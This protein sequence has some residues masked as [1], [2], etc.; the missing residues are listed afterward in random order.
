[1]T[2]KPTSTIG[3]PALLVPA[4]LVALAGQAF[5]GHA[6]CI[7]ELPD[8]DDDRE[9]ASLRRRALYIWPGP[10]ADAA[11]DRA[12]TAGCSRIAILDVA[13]DLLSGERCEPGHLLHGAKRLAASRATAADLSIVQLPAAEPMALP[14]DVFGPLAQPLSACAHWAATSPDYVGALALP[15]LSGLTGG[16]LVA[17]ITAAHAEPVIV[18]AA[19][20]GAPGSNKTGA[21]RVF[22]PGL[23]A[24]EAEIGAEHERLMALWQANN[25]TK[26]K[27]QREK[28]PAREL[29]RL[30]DFTSEALAFAL[31]RNGRGL[32]GWVPEFSSLSP[33]LGLTGDQSGYSRT[34]SLR[35]ALLRACLD[36]GR[37]MYSRRSAGDE[38]LPIRNFA[39]P[40]ATT[41]QPDIFSELLR[42][43]LRDGLA[44]RFV[45]AMPLYDPAAERGAA[46]A[47]A[48]ADA[49]RR[50]AEGL[51]RIRKTARDLEQQGQVRIAF[52]PEA[53]AAWDVYA[54][55]LRLR[56]AGMNDLV[57][58]ARIKA[59]AIVARIAALGALI[60][61]AL[62][63]ADLQVTAAKFAQARA[64]MR[65]LLDHRAVAEACA[66]EPLDER[67]A[68]ALARAI[69]AR[70]AT[71]ISPTDVRRHWRVTN[72]RTEP[73]VR[74]ALIELQLAGWLR[75]T[76]P[77]SRNP[78]DPLPAQVEIDPTVLRDAR[79]LMRY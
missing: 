55:Q 69:V 44:D 67:R 71:L 53:A 19:A 72:L 35:A 28:Q 79:T 61:H 38:P 59:T 66:F 3:L 11:A 56:A 41:V 26:P 13:P 25:A 49:T 27:G 14:L 17:M 4:G 12:Q 62:A 58:G 29:I 68:R 6:Q 52:S 39:A 54:R 32:I 34:G 1:M 24:I 40:V 18:A 64:L 10:G 20:L 75:N 9:W 2:N 42:H 33:H 47:L 21:F 15:V 76:S 45:I 36:G 60:D 63:G 70:D 48:H 30:E 57:G 23:Q 51:V 74:S 37:S 73:E 5:A 16:N 65:A 43:P 31:H 46:P 22:E 8:R 7:A 78:R 77:I 50:L